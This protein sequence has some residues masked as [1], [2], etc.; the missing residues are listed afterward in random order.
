MPS[1]IDLLLIEALR[2]IMHLQAETVIDPQHKYLT[3]PPSPIHLN[4]LSKE[5]YQQIL[6]HS[7]IE[8]N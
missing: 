8:L 7:F 4:N 3:L 2:P 1:N 6:I 5:P